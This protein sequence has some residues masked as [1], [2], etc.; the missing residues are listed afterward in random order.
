MEVIIFLLALV[1][2][3]VFALGG[4]GSA[5]ILVPIM[6]SLGIPINSAKPIGLFINTV[7]MTGA[8]INNIKNKRLDFKIGIPI[9]ISSFIFAVIGA[10]TSKF[11]PTK[12]VIGVFVLFLVFSGLMF[13]FHKKKEGESYR[14]DTPYVKLTLIGILAGLLSG[15]LGIG[16]GGVISPLMLMIGVNP[17]KIT[18]ITAF[19][20]PFSSLS[21]FITYWIM[22]SVNWR[23][24]IIATTAGLIGA[25]LG[26]IFMQKK[27]NVQTV[28]MILAIILLLMAVKMIFKLF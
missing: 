24:L 1:A 2:S 26:T 28:K 12:I 3:F 6:V 25:T 27:L 5:I 18:A 13:L 22:G 4:I 14:T 8:S 15:I 10:Y 21:G 9:I 11:I 23:L 19:V 17:K 16:G 7:S 20:V